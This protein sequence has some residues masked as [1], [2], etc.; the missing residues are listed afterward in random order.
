MSKKHEQK[1]EINDSFACAVYDL[2]EI[3]LDTP[4]WK[5]AVYA[6]VLLC[7][8]G[9]K[10]RIYKPIPDYAGHDHEFELRRLESPEGECLRPVLWKRIVSKEPDE[11]FSLFYSKIIDSFQSGGSPDVSYYMAVNNLLSPK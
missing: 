11:D 9:Y 7:A 8:Y 4:D 2:A 6:L 10:V 3:A 1:S 5:F